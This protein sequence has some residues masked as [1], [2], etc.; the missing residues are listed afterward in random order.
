MLAD[1][2]GKTQSE[3]AAKKARSGMKIEC[4]REFSI[5]IDCAFLGS[6]AI[7]PHLLFSQ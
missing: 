5:F 4:V 3:K 7:Y 1:C 2:P 6:W